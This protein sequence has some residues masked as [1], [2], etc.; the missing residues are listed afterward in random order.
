M[1]D[2][3]FLRLSFKD[4]SE[5]PSSLKIPVYKRDMLLGNRHPVA[6]KTCEKVICGERLAKIEIRPIEDEQCYQNQQVD[7]KANPSLGIQ[8]VE[9][10][11]PEEY[12]YEGGKCSCPNH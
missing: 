3:Y 10:S 6:A 12:E 2:Q 8:L 4:W 11:I 7:Q 1:P 5:T 9:L